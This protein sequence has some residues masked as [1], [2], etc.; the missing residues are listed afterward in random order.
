MALVS[1]MAQRPITE[2]P[3]ALIVESD[4]PY[5][6]QA[7]AIGI[8]PMNR[9]ILKPF[10]SNYALVAQPGR[11]SRVMTSKVQGSNPCGRTTFNTPL[12]Q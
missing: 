8:P 4:A 12:A 3:H 1:G 7:M 6:G 10:L 5:T 9:K 11:A 2:I